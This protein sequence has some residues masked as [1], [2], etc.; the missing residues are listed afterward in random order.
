M[1]LLAAGQ[2]RWP[3]QV[4]RAVEIRLTLQAVGKGLVMNS[5]EV[6]ARTDPMLCR[7]RSCIVFVWLGL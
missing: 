2:I 5:S 3:S 6:R 4:R 7:D 1:Q